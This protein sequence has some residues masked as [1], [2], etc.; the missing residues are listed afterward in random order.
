MS[1]YIGTA[2]LSLLITTA[3]MPSPTAAAQTAQAEIIFT[4][5]FIIYP[6]PPQVRMAQM[7]HSDH[8]LRP[9]GSHNRD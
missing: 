7:E 9:N 2:F 4:G 6:S 8:I 5:L 3:K 1:L